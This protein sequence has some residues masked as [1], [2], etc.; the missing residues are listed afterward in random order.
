MTSPPLL[1]RL[2]IAY[3]KERARQVQVVHDS[4]VHVLDPGELR[5]LRRVTQ[6]AVARAALAGALSAL[7][8]ALAEVLANERFGPSPATQDGQLRW[9]ALVLGVTVVAS[10]VEI[11]FLYLD[12]LRAVHQLT[13]VAGLELFEDPSREQAAVAQALARAAL[14]LPNP[15]RG[16]YG[17]DARREAPR[18]ELFLASLAYKLKTSVSNFLFKA[19]V[20]RALGRTALR[21]YLNALLPF[22]A[23]PVTALWNG[24]VAWLVL[25]EAR[26]RAVGPSAARQLVRLCLPE[27]PRSEAFAEA[28]MQAVA[29]SIVK[30]AD[31]HPNLAALLSEVTAC[32]GEP[33]V[34]SLGDSARFLECLATLSPAEARAT[35]RLLCVAVIIDGK[36]HRSERALLVQAFTRCGM[37]LD[38][39]ALRSLRLALLRG[40]PLDNAMIEALDRSA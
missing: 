27:A 25:R 28:A 7:A 19:L 17:I 18:L 16:L 10:I 1:E 39:A 29:C 34:V 30:T 2:G 24:L 13:V 33:Q 32:I 21:G 31:L 15:P 37:R 35:L 23:V 9:W 4:E 22:V 20:R 36:L 6:G 3:L 26:L 14:E 11:A 5:A 12:S 38:E 40:H 8:S